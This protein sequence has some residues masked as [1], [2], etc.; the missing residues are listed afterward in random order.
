MP[1]QA[2]ISNVE[3]SFILEAL[4]QNLRLDNRKFDQHR[5]TQLTFGEQYGTVTVNVGKTT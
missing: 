4:T 2:D 1:R 5:P 3:K